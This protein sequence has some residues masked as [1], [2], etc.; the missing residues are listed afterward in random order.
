MHQTMCPMSELIKIKIIYIKRMMSRILKSLY[1]TRLY[2]EELISW[3]VA[4][5]SG[6]GGQH[7]NTSNSKAMMLYPIKY[8]ESEILRVI[9]KNKGS[10]ISKDSLIITCQKHRNFSMNQKEC[11]EYFGN[12]LEQTRKDLQPRVTCVEKVEKIEKIKEISNERRL[13]IKRMHSE[14]KN[15]RRIDKKDFS[16]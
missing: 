12:L 2:R 4:R 14:M 9:K 10:L 15:S 1:S 3:K 13:W 8:I 5:S 7:A 11:I 6:P 16:V